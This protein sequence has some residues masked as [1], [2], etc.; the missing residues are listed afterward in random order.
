MTTI[1]IAREVFALFASV[2]TLLSS[3][4]T[5]VIDCIEQLLQKGEIQLRCTKV[6]HHVMFVLI[7]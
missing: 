6:E 5:E 3:L 7:R 1:A 2:H 4:E